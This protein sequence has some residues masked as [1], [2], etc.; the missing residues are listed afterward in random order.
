MRMYLYVKAGC[1]L[2]KKTSICKRVFS[3]LLAIALVFSCALTS[4]AGNMISFN[5]DNGTGKQPI[6]LTSNGGKILYEMGDDYSGSTRTQYIGTN[7]VGEV[8]KLTAAD[9]ATRTF[10]FWLDEYSGRVYSYDR[11]VSFTVASR[12]HLRAQ[13]AVVSDTEHF[14]TYVNYGGN[15]LLDSD[16]M[17]AFDEDINV[18]AAGLLPGFTFQRWSMTEQEIAAT[19]EDVVVYPIYTVN[20]E[21]YTV[22]ITNDAY[23]SGAGT[24]QNL[25][26]VHL[27]AEP[28]NGEGQ[29]FSYWKD[30]SG[31]V[32]SYERNYSFRIN[33]NISLTA[34]YGE[35]VTPAPVA[36]VSKIVP[37]TTEFKIT[38]YAE[39]SVPTD[40]TVLSHG[41]LVSK[42]EQTEDS[43]IVSAAGDSAT[44]GIR[45]VYGNSNEN[46]GTFSVAQSNVDIG[47]S[48]YVRPFLIVK[49]AA[50]AQFIV[51]GDIVSAANG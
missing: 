50:D 47:Q 30:S 22:K 43:M 41:L 49:N 42:T 34:V 14:V 12:M 31:A 51:Y 45:K 27:K 7:P 40:Y 4:L 28:V 37:D 6:K 33:Y 5:G 23:V 2:M 44:A 13:F 32:V 48:V 35:D 3:V 8:V 26:T 25:Q 10:M 29:A 9:T 36:R 39:R 17:Y 15:K 19:T 11:S 18:P 24:Y 46:C 20:S 16:P 21:S 38:F 1:S